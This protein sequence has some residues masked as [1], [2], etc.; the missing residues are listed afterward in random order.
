LK[1]N[2]KKSIVIFLGYTYIV[3]LG[4]FVIYKFGV[5]LVKDSKK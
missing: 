5:F 2:I 1:Y 4:L 3:L